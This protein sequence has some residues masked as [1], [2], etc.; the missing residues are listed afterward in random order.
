LDTEVEVINKEFRN[1]AD[2]I[3]SAKLQNIEEESQ[4][5]G[6]SSLRESELRRL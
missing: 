5:D 1:T 3:L 2:R 4:D 6:G